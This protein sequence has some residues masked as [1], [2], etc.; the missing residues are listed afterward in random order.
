M[1]AD[2]DSPSR[3][4]FLRSLVGGS[5][6]LPAILSEL[7]A[8]ER[9]PPIRSR[10]ETRTSPRRR[11]RVI[12]LFSTGGVSHMDTFDH[13]PT[14]F[15]ADGRMTGVGGG[16]SLEQRPLLRP[17]LGLSPRRQV[18]HARQRP[19]SAPARAHGRHL[20]HQLDDDRQQRALPGH[21]R[22]PYRLVLLSPAR[23]WARGSAMAWARSTS[24]LPSFV[25][26]A[27]NLPYAGTQVFA[28]DFLPAYHQGTRVVPGGDPIPNLRRA[29]P[30]SGDRRL[31]TNGT[32][33][34]P[35]LQPG[36]STP[37]RPRLR[38][39]GPHPHLRDR[40]SDAVRGAGGFRPLA[41]D[42]RDARA[43][44]VSIAATR[45]ASPG[46]ASSPA[47]SPNAV[48]ASSN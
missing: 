28:N 47:D 39:G 22:H 38:T 7:L 42:R 35:R 27:P 41:R 33:P 37:Q 45:R 34:G 6:L 13:K 29:A 10:R 24:N 16:L 31:A 12:F 48:S 2:H 5:A 25:V 4:H 30:P 20:P 36:A 14:L 8:D 17:A 23:A 26:L 46:N 11:A 40:L 15:Q 1:P 21:A 3:R 19:L 32:G 9:P 43:F 18:R 44:M